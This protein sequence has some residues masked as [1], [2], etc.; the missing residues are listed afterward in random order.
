[1]D[2]QAFNAYACDKLWKRSDLPWWLRSLDPPGQQFAREVRRFQTAHGLKPIDGKLGKDT[3]SEVQR[4]ERVRMAD[5]ADDYGPVDLPNTVVAPTARQELKRPTTD[6]QGVLIHTTGTGLYAAAVKAYPKLP[7]DEALERVVRNLLSAPTSYTSNGYI[8]PNGKTLLTVPVDEKAVHAGVSTSL[9]GIYAKGYTEWSQW[10]GTCDADLK[11]AAAPGRYDTWKALA[12]ANGIASP[13]DLFSGDPNRRTWA[14]DLVAQPGQG[15]ADAYTDTQAARAAEL[16]E[17]ASRFFGFTIGFRTVQ[18]HQFTNPIC[19]WPW[20]P[21]PG[22]PRRRLG[23]ALRAI[24]C[25]CALGGDDI[26]G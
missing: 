9:R 4:Q 2:A 18:Y 25:D 15:G 3:W 1:M 8:L 20:D 6:V 19:R 11:R 17:W 26:G 16:V 10:R 21:G 13:L 12:D 24:G 5:T 22:F 14:F 23:D 7:I